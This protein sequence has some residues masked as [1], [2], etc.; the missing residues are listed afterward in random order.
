M[1]EIFKSPLCIHIRRSAMGKDYREERRNDPAA[2]VR[3]ECGS[4]QCTVSA[5]QRSGV[6][7]INGPGQHRRRK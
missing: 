2:L 3:K 5:E 6:F 4:L 7:V 1:Y